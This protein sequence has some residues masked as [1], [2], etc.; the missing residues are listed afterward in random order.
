MNEK[1]RGIRTIGSSRLLAPVEN[2]DRAVSGPAVTRLDQQSA[3][4]WLIPTPWV[5]ERRV[6]VPTPL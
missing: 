3:A 1:N 5:E 2:N 6:R 4:G